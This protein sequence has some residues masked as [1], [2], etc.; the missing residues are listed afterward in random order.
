[1]IIITGASTNHILSLQNMIRSFVMNNSKNTLIVY[2]LGIEEYIWKK[3]QEVFQERKEIIF[4][5]FDY[6][7][8]PEW[9]N[10]HIEAGQYAWKPAIIFKTYIEYCNEIIVWMDAGNLIKTDLSEL[11]SYI[12]EYQVYSATSNG[13]ISTW[14]HPKTIK[15]MNCNWINQENRNAAC[16]GFN[17]KNDVVKRFI[18]E[19]Y[20][21]AC[22]K[23]CIA[24]E[25]SNRSN[26]RQDQSV[27]TILYYKY[28]WN[29]SINGTKYI[30]F[31]IHNDVD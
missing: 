29:K 28:K 9:Y 8:Y 26:H 18:T 2:D 31:S 20:N 25:G 21:Y 27:F 11:E 22:I 7:K 17:T 14:T 6:S 10:I 1:M 19:F 30:G 3:L 16:L 4:K 12:L 13:S 24:P 23:S 5:V 15:C